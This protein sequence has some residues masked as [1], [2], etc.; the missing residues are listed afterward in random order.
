MEQKS[1]DRSKNGGQ[2]KLKIGHALKKQKRLAKLANLFKR[3]SIDPSSTAES[4]TERIEPPE[5]WSARRL[6]QNV[7]ES[8]LKR[9]E[10]LNAYRGTTRYKRVKKSAKRHSERLL[11]QEDV[12]VDE[13]VPYCRRLRQTVE[14]RR[15]RKEALATER[16]A[17]LRFIRLERARRAHQLRYWK[18]RNRRA[19]VQQDE[20]ED[21]EQEMIDEDCK[22]DLGTLSVSLLHQSIIAIFLQL[23]LFQETMSYWRI[24]IPVI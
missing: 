12:D 21:S 13:D 22:I 9:V 20:Q 18:G 10:L 5:P 15:A 17:E 11:E 7:R 24:P 1:P 14:R 8:E 19:A 2:Y 6:R 16:A 23:L 4:S 3:K